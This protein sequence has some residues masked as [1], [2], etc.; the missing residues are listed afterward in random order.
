MLKKE[1]TII[2]YMVLGSAFK[3][4]VALRHCILK[5]KDFFIAFKEKRGCHARKNKQTNKE[6]KSPG[7]K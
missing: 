5:K 2:G 3:V 1:R 6:T 4:C 7:I